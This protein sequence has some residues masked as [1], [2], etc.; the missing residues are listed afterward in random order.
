[1]RFMN[2]SIIIVNYNTRKLLENCLNSLFLYCKK[3][4]TSGEYEIIVVDNSSKDGSVEYLRE[5]CFNDTYHQYISLIANINN[6]GFAKANNIGIKEAKGDLI[7]LLNS[8]TEVKNGAI[9]G[10]VEFMSDPPTLKSFG[11]AKGV[12]TCKI[13]LGN[14]KIDPA[15]HR[16]FPTLWNAF[17]YFTRFEKLFTKFKIFSGYHQYYKNLDSVHEVDAISGAFFMVS[18]KVI[19]DVGLLDEDYFMYGEDLDWCYRIKQ[20]GYKIWYNP[21]FQIIHYKKQSGRD[22]GDSEV[23]KSTQK[24]FWQTMKIFYEKHYVKKYPK[25]V[26]WF[27]EKIIGNLGSFV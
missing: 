6:S 13:L 21:N 17:C 19:D 5:L 20:A 25:I 4:L 26:N 14:G 27:V 15:C 3:E 11:E 8:D 1:M 18:R 12:A 2:L 7:L 22:S 9:Q 10:M 16:G 23:K 24:Y